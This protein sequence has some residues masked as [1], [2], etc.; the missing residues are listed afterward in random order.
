MN[1]SATD[2]W[3]YVGN[4][5]ICQCGLRRVRVCSGSPERPHLHG[6]VLCDD[7]E[8]LWREPSLGSAQALPENELPACPVCRLPLYG[9]QARWATEQDLVELGWRDQCV[10]EPV[11]A[12]GD[13]ED[14]LDPE[15]FATDLDSPEPPETHDSDLIGHNL[16]PA[17]QLADITPQL[18][19]PDEEAE[20]RPGC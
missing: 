18:D 6:Y 17:E 14:L 2:A 12:V 19:E 9:P 5:P 13:H 15:D 8:T 10:V 1:L 20:P 4:C 16:T 11:R 3:I 7:C